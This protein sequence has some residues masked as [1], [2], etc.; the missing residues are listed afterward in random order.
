MST[1]ITQDPLET[2]RSLTNHLLSSS[3]AAAYTPTAIEKFRQQDPEPFDVD[4]RLRPFQLNGLISETP[5]KRSEYGEKKFGTD[6]WNCVCD[7][8]ASKFKSVG[9]N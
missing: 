1:Q 8:L 3:C 6:R 2:S 4:I 5:M 9:I 7:S